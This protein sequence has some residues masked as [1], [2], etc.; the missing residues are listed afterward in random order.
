M[1]SMEHIIYYIDSFEIVSEDLLL[2][3]PLIF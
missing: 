3:T 2:P 1:V